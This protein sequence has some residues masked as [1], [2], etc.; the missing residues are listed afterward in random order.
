VQL[1]IDA[2]KSTSGEAARD[3]A[4]IALGRLVEHLD[5]LPDP[6]P[7]L[8]ADTPA[9]PG[10]AGV[11]A[12]L[13]AT[14]AAQGT[15]ASG[16]LVRQGV[17]LRL[18]G[19]N[20]PVDNRVGAVIAADLERPAMAKALGALDADGTLDHLIKHVT[21]AVAA[22]P[23]ETRRSRL[24]LL[25]RYEMARQTVRQR[26]EELGTFDAHADWQR[27]RVALDPRV[28]ADAALALARIAADAGAAADIRELWGERG[29][30]TPEEMDELLRAYLDAGRSVPQADSDRAF[31]MLMAVPLSSRQ[32]KRGHVGLTLAELPRGAYERSD[33]YAWLAAFPPDDNP[34]AFDRWQRRTVFA[35][36]DRQR[37]VPDDRWDELINIAG[38]VL[39]RHRRDPTFVDAV[40][41]FQATNFERVCEAIGKAL[42]K[43][44]EASRNKPKFAAEEF[45]LWIRIRIHGVVDQVLPEAF[46]RLSGKDVEQVGEL[47]SEPAVAH[48]ETWA[49]R[50]PRTGA[51]A[52]VARALRRKDKDRDK[53]R[54]K[55]AD[56]EKDKRAG[57]R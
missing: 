13:R 33:Y 7:A 12:W 41:R 9:A 16:R 31:R 6:F 39:S 2:R 23:P 45:D 37:L 3:L 38:Q 35:L 29:P 40:K 47:V 19:L 36:D 28:R 25:A 48:W 4:T 5:N 43:E 26:A 57:A 20:V 42:A 22:E 8:P 18:I 15:D 14:E 21:D 17:Q 55:G 24:L 51:R 11:G 54:D 1:Y 27:L 32:P 46:R 50:H 30:Q 53:D 10:V 34:G 44:V 52:A 49:E 56:N